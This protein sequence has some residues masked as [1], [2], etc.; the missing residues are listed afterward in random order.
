MIRLY[1]T[2][3]NESSKCW[4]FGATYPS[5]PVFD[6]KRVLRELLK[7]TF[8]SHALKVKQ[9]LSLSWSLRIQRREVALK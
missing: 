7:D 6:V 5:I 8:T 4:D 1:Q 9:A 2:R 3:G